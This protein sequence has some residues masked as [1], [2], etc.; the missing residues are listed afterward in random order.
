MPEPGEKRHLRK[1][2]F[3][4]V[5]Y[6]GNHGNQLAFFKIPKKFFSEL[7]TEHPGPLIDISLSV[8]NFT[9]SMVTQILLH[10]SKYFETALKTSVGDA[11]SKT[12]MDVIDCSLEVLTCAVNFMYGI[13]IPEDF[14][15]TQGLLHQADLFMMEDL[16]AAVGYLIT[17]TLSLDTLST[18]AP[19]AEKY[20]EVTLQK[21]CGDFILAHIDG[22]E[23][24]VISELALSMPSIAGKALHTVQDLKKELALAKSEQEEKDQSHQNALD[25][26]KLECARKIQ[27]A[28]EKETKINSHIQEIGS[29]VLGIHMYRNQFKKPADFPGIV[30]TAEY[31][32]YVKGNIEA[33][34]L[35]RCCQNIY[36]NNINDYGLC[37]A[38]VGDIGRIINPQL[39]G[40]QVKWQNGITMMQSD[41]FAQLELLTNPL[42][43]SFLA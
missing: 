38:E 2:S 11:K 23:E 28:K 17:K 4:T 32:A 13:P 39:S 30:G 40:V 43:T 29:K 25:S 12:E 42:N 31:K 26:T 41:C 34:M 1:I 36:G 9:F 16:K 19:L 7:V 14:V 15:D 35:V 22:L 33:N 21:I 5:V 18:I 20:R 37:T 24:N 6:L 10:R 27:E 3:L 8:M